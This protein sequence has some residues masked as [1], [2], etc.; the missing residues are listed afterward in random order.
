MASIQFVIEQI[1]QDPSRAVEHLPI[2]EVCLEL[3]LDWRERCLDPATTLALFMRQI[4][5]GNSSCALVRHG[6]DKRFS[7]QAYCKARKRLSLAVIQALS[8]RLC[9]AVR[10]TRQS[11]A[12][13]LFLTHRVFVVDGSNFSMPD[14]PQLQKKFGQSGAQKPG[15]GFPVAHLLAMFDVNTGMLIEAIAAPMRTHDLANVAQMHP[16]LQEGDLLMGDTAFGSYSHF[17]LLLQAKVH[18]LMPNHQQRIIDFTPDRPFVRPKDQTEDSKG[19]PRSRWIKSL[20]VEDQLVEWFKSAGRPKYMSK[21]QYAAMAESIIVRE[22]R[23]RVW[24][25]EL[26]SWVE[27]EIVTTLLDPVIYPVEKLVELRLRRWQV[28]VNLRHLKTTMGLEVLKCKT[29]EG[30]Q[31]EMAVFA[32]V[33]NLV[34]V[35]M[36][37]AAGRQN[38]QPDRISFAD[39]LGWIRVVRPDRPMP[40]FIVNPIRRGRIEPR[41]KK[42]RPK[43]YDL[44]NRP[45]QELREALKKQAQKACGLS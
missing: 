15:C 11:V 34:R 6:S 28:E 24:R 22:I 19:L 44:M 32:L 14:T 42:R 25:E 1:K 27:L 21:E 16:H 5:D 20:G 29:V 2:R 26:K 33:Y 36:L 23:R 35:L 18:A 31:K 8:R 41:V 38:T 17:A 9:D 12:V 4:M 10:A 7:P 37:E 13:D 45:R 3:G 39:V 30:V 40:R 43:P